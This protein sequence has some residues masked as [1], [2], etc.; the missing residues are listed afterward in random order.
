MDEQKSEPS[1]MNLETTKEEPRT[2]FIPDNEDPS[3][4]FDFVSSSKL[5]KGKSIFSM[6]I[7][8]LC[9]A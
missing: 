2:V 8:H 6:F 4:K 1:N 5:P 9:N 7:I 3:T